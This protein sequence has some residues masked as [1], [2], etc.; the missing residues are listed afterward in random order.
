MET[1]FHTFHRWLNHCTSALHAPHTLT[2]K[3]HAPL[4]S[5]IFLVHFFPG[6][7]QPCVC[8]YHHI[9]LCLTTTQSPLR[10]YGLG[11]P[12]HACM[13][14][15]R[16]TDEA[17]L[18]ECS[19]K[20]WFDGACAVCC[21][22]FEELCLVANVGDAKAVLARRPPPSPSRTAEKVRINSHTHADIAKLSKS[23]S[24]ICIPGNDA[25]ENNGLTA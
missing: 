4:Q 16:L 12:L 22:V 3:K 9:L 19:S 17:L 11:S 2:E 15:F 20:A 24:L 1:F 18:R 10:I 6:I 21:W 7:Y 5:Y 25:I 14:A 13:Q 8:N 23:E